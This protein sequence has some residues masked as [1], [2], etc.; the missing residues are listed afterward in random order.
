MDGGGGCDSG[1]S[2]ET[3]EEEK[4]G[5]NVSGWLPRGLRSP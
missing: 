4:R 5:Q 2:G 3:K 1:G